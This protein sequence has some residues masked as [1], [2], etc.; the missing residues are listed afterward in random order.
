MAPRKFW[1]SVESIGFDVGILIFVTK[2][3]DTFC[4]VLESSSPHSLLV[5]QKFENLQLHENARL[6]D[7]LVRRLT[8]V[9]VVVTRD[10]L[11]RFAALAAD[12]TFLRSIEESWRAAMLEST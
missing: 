3:N 9:G 2:R 1:N 8:D 5:L 7:V 6:L 12:R 11:Q 10:D 4:K